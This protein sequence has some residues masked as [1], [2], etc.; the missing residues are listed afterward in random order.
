MENENKPV[1]KRK[2]TIVF[3]VICL[4]SSICMILS[5]IIGVMDNS[6]ALVIVSVCLVVVFFASAITG[7]IVF[8]VQRAKHKDDPDYVIR[9][10][11]I[12]VCWIL[13][14]VLLLMSFIGNNMG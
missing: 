5:A 3:G 10:F 12:Y 9:S 13:P 7:I 11:P 6:I 4:V 2:N 8:Y 1:G 14:I